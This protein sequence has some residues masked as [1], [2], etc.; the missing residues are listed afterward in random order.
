MNRDPSVFHVDRLELAFT[1]KPWVFAVERRAEI[2]AFFAK[3][4]REKPALWNGRVLLLHHQIMT[5][6]VFRG[7]Y[8]ETD[9]ASFAAWTHWGRPAAAAH[10]CFGAAAIVAADGAFLLGVM[11]AHT[12]NAGQIYLPCGTPDPDD[13]ADGKVDLDFSVRRELK[14]ET[15]FDAVEFS[16]EPGWTTV[17]DGAL[18][19]QIKVLHAREDAD[20]LRTRILDHLARETQ[21]ELADIRIVRGAADFDP[22]MPRFVSVFLAHRFAGG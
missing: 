3:M 16:A 17:V 20:A 9:Y 21:P 6:G 22:M 7:D 19:A 11:G 14:E 15:G 8:L 12:F 1:P 13:I 5:E 4:Q 18:I 10:D 2:D